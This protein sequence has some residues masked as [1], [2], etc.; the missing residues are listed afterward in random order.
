MPLSNGDHH[1]GT[2]TCRGT[3]STVFA[4]A[5]PVGDLRG[6]QPGMLVPVHSG[7]RDGLQSFESDG[8]QV[9][10]PLSRGVDPVIALHPGPR[11]PAKS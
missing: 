6:W 4:N 9:T 2:S 8:V 5:T 3:S 1:R 10:H 11:D 7:L